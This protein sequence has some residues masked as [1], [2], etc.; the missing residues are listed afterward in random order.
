MSK[1]NRSKRASEAVVPAQTNESTSP[2]FI[3]TVKG[4]GVFFMKNPAFLPLFGLAFFFWFLTS[5]FPTYEG[6]VGFFDKLV[7]VL[8]G[9][10]FTRQ[11]AFL[12]ILVAAVVFAIALLFRKN[13]AAWILL[14]VASSS[15]ASSFFFVVAEHWRVSLL[16][17]R[18]SR[19]IL[20]YA[21]KNAPMTEDVVIQYL[22]VVHRS[23][24]DY[25][26]FPALVTND[27]R[28]NVKLLVHGM[29]KE[30][31]ERIFLAIDHLKRAGFI[32]EDESV[33]TLSIDEGEHYHDSLR[34]KTF[35][36]TR[37]GRLFCSC[38]FKTRKFKF[39]DSLFLYEPILPVEGS[40]RSLSRLN[41]IPIDIYSD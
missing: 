40:D 29:A 34:I 20:F 2:S 36:V 18:D 10:V 26:S 15:I 4:W 1:K 39:S 28:N 17:P 31:V 30:D 25:S 32:T 19:Q 16:V 33:E 7:F 38:Y 21:A 9:A 22:T 35:R 14:S 13:K 8:G 41:K 23:A 6:T 5:K 12:I 11:A 3:E 37:R 27:E 24:D